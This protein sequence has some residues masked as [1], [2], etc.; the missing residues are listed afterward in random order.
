MAV[1][2]SEDSFRR[3]FEKIRD[4]HPASAHSW[5]H[6]FESAGRLA[7]ADH[8]VMER[9]LG[10]SIPKMAATYGEFSQAVLELSL[11]HI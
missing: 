2:P 6:G 1:C 3:Q 4:G 9:Y 5:R 11:I 8:I 10:H 7:E